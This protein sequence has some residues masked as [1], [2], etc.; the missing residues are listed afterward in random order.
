MD[1]LTNHFRQMHIRRGGD[2]TCDDGEA[3]RHQRFTGDTRVHVLSEDR[4]EHS[5]GDLVGDLVRMPLGDGFRGE[6]MTVGH[7]TLEVRGIG[8][9][10]NAFDTYGSAL[11]ESGQPSGTRLV[12][13]KLGTQTTTQ[14]RLHFTCR[15]SRQGLL[16]RLNGG[17]EAYASYDAFHPRHGTR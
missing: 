8:L 5:V 9:N 2:L 15:A 12:C 3:G 4:I 10:A 7:A 11:D 14:E 1:G 13:V 16:R 17:G 6:E